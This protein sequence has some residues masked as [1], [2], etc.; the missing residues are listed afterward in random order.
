[1]GAAS[2]R[3]R[4]DWEKCDAGVRQ[5]PAY[6]ALREYLPGDD[7][8]SLQMQAN[9]SMA[10]PGQVKDLFTVHSASA[11]CRKIRLEAVN[12]INPALV[13]PVA[14]WFTRLDSAY[15]D[16]AERRLTWG[17]FA[18]QIEAAR[19]QAKARFAAVA[20][21]IQRG[22]DQSHTAEVARR[23]QATHAL[24]QWSAQQ[25]TLVQQQK[26]IGAVSTSQM[27][28][29]RYVGAQLSCTTF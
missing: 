14:E 1:M 29:C 6:Q 18:Q 11:S 17:Q 20:A 8:P 12:S 22:L 3:G 26:A 16:V 15:V 9:T 27:T 2:D 23:V 5:L 19:V 7:P 13:A 28:D 25:Q 21:D 10:T 4:L 24:Q